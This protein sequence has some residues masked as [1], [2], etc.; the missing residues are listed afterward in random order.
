MKLNNLISSLQE[1]E[2]VVGNID[3][4][5]YAYGGD[6]GGFYIQ[7]GFT[8]NRRD[9]FFDQPDVPVSKEMMLDLQYGFKVGWFIPIYQRKPKEYYFE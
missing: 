7:E 8:F 2:K 9:V 6:H 1:L 4:V 5:I 3:T